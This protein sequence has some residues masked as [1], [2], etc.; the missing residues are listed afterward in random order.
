MCQLAGTATHDRACS[1]TADCVSGLV[2]ALAGFTTRCVAPGTADAGDACIEDR[3]C[4]AGL[5]CGDASGVAFCVSPP[6]GR[7]FP[8]P[9]LWSGERC[10]TDDAEAR[11]YFEVPRGGDSDG[12]F[13]RLPYPND[14]RRTSSGLLLATH[15]R[16]GAGA[17][18][19]VVDR[20]LVASEA[21]LRGF[22]TNPTV[23]FRFSQPFDPAFSIDALE[24][25]DITPGSPTYGE[26]SAVETSSDVRSRYL[27]ANSLAMR[28]P[29][30]A[31][32][33]PATTY[34]AV[35][36]TAV[37]RDAASGGGPFARA[38]DLDALLDVSE[39][40]DAGLLDGY[41]AYA[42]LRAYL[43]DVA[44]DPATVL[45]AAVFTTQPVED[46]VPRLREV[47]RSSPAPTLT[48]LT[49][50]DRG[51]ASPCDDYT[52]LRRCP[53]APAADFVEIHGRI[54][55]PIFQS[56]TAPYAA[57]DD[58]GDIERDTTGAPIVA[59]TE[60]VCFALTIPTA[61]MPPDG[62]PLL[63][64]AHGEG[65][66]FRVAVSE[67]FAG[68]LSAPDAPV[69]AATLTIDL[70]QNGARR[71]ASSRPSGE[72]FHNLDN[73]RAARGNLLQGA[74]DLYALVYFATTYSASSATSPTGEPLDFD[75]SRMALFAHGQ[76][77]Q[78]ATLM[79]PW[80]PEIEAAALSGAGGGF[81][82]SL[83]TRTQPV[84]FAR[85]LPDALR[86]TRAAAGIAFG[87]WHPVV[88][89]L[90]QYFD[91]VDPVNYARRFAR[92][93]MSG[94]R[95]AHLFITFG[96]GDSHAT[97]PTVQALARAADMPVVR[98]VLDDWGLPEVG[99]PVSA[100][101]LV[102][103]SLRTYGLRQY[104]P[105]GR[106]DGHFVATRTEDGRADVLRFLSDALAGENPTIGE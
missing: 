9:E 3:S 82:Q 23:Y 97:G 39:P 67:G 104:L 22:S 14:V 90:Q 77:A 91:A 26:R 95:G 1:M 36:S 34:A 54:A 4:V 20:Y 65:D 81:A 42:P 33:R 44:R 79:L 21:D 99:A 56:G 73:P 24:L 19:D 10:P 12:D 86:D 15:P 101:R 38:P 70:P 74:A 68:D 106:D 18:I 76:G 32:L 28:T 49:V 16:P 53:S 100:N 78:H 61:P 89:L 37:V 30:G 48:D 46:L 84:H 92:E 43:T 60:P 27:C 72:L 13:Y 58:G 71:G 75:A 31:P 59:R 102:G 25:V 40:A 6:A 93:P 51:A 62:W 96:Q 69:R 83:L 55:L 85:T 88:A 103:A 52:G 87:E 80:E 11:A 66:S 29:R 57:P 8:T 64:Y 17:G 98:P 5:S 7:D 41:T 2:C 63:L 94:R 35:V 47:I 45:S 50:C 105:D